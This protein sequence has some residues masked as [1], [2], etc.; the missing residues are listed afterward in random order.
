[1]LPISFWRNFDLFRKK[2]I[3]LAQKLTKLE[4]VCVPTPVCFSVSPL[5]SS[6]S[7][8]PEIGT[9]G[10]VGVPTYCNHAVIFPFFMNYDMPEERYVVYLKYRNKTITRIQRVCLASAQIPARVELELPSTNNHPPTHIEHLHCLEVN[11]NDIPKYYNQN[12]A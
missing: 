9:M 6:V 8:P 11:Q 2:N 12:T 7:P 4:H 3:F 1:M 5:R 10:G